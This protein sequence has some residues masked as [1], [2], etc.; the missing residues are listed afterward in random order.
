MKDATILTH[1]GENPRE[2][3]GAVVPPI[4]QNSLFTF[5]DWDGIADAFSNPH[6]NCI[7]SRGNNPSSLLVEQK[8][9]ALAGGEKAK[10]FA[11]GMGAISSAIM[12]CLK[13]GDHAITVRNVYGPTSQFFNKYLKEKCNI[14][15][16]FVEGSDIND[17]VQ[18]IRPNTRLIYLE[19]P[20]S[21][22]FSLQDIRKVVELAK[23]NNIKTVIDNTWATP[24]YQKPL[25]LGVD[26]EVHSC[27]KYFGGHSDLVAGVAIASAEIIEAISENEFPLFGAKIAPFE[28]WLIMR[29]LR[30]MHLRL[31]QHEANALKVATF[32]EQHQN[33]VRV[34]YPGLPSFPQFALAQAQMSGSS[35]L[36]SFEL[37]TENVEVVKAFINA[38]EIFSIGVSWGGHE[39]LVI[40]PL[41]GF[42]KERPIE[43]FKSTGLS[44]GL[45]RVSIGLEDADDL[46]DDINQAL[47]V[48]FK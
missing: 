27:S 6:E 1:L 2:Y 4:Y 30:T 25:K 46:I 31:K 38:L 21:N 5:E 8:I 11:S 9:A 10:L 13:A 17:F 14:D 22:L 29:S 32:L 26:I 47:N 18:A 12:H 45:V 44:I 23:Q 48:A 20:S 16:T 37:K 35:G 7:Y 33:I 41:V 39:S 40:S 28:A 24:L 42:L 3:K 36:F 43:E 34:N 15:V 19:S